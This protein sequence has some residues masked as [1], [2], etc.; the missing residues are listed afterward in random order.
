MPLLGRLASGE[1]AAFAGLV[2][3]QECDDLV[4]ARV[5]GSY[6]LLL[7]FTPAAVEVFDVVDRRD[8]QRRVKALRAKGV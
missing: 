3:I 5:A 6:R 2:K 4:R 8:L 7:R 1:P